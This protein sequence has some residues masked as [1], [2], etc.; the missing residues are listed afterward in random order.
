MSQTAVPAL[1]VRGSD[2][3]FRGKICKAY[4]LAHRSDWGQARY[5]WCK[6]AR[7]AFVAGKV[8]SDSGDKITVFVV[9]DGSQVCAVSNRSEIAGGCREK[10]HIANESS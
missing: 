4:V 10:E 9:P 6:D 2:N 3:R 5:V 1:S 8:L 7:N